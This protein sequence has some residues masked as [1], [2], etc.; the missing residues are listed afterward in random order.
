MEIRAN[1]ITTV[2]KSF[3]PLPLNL[4]DLADE[5]S[6]GL[7]YEITA[8]N[9][10]QGHSRVIPYDSI[11]RIIFR[12]C[13]LSYKCIQGRGKDFQS[14]VC[15][16]PVCVCGGWGEGLLVQLYCFNNSRKTRLGDMFQRHNDAAPVY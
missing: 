1:I 4:I 14:F 9:Q 8:Q 7:K 13:L 6:S 11:V 5:I 10:Y 15:L 2:K 16:P 12:M 3:D